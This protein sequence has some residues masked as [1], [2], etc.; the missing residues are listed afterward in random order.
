MILEHKN[1]DYKNII[2][3][4]NS[5]KITDDTKIKGFADLFKEATT[6]N[7]FYGYFEDVNDV[8]DLP[9]ETRVTNVETWQTFYYEIRQ[10]RALLNNLTTAKNSFYKFLKY[11]NADTNESYWFYSLPRGFSKGADTI[12]ME[13][14]LNKLVRVP[15]LK[16]D[17]SARYSFEFIAKISDTVGVCNIT[18]RT[19]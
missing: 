11:T 12:Q 4:Y 18:N 9:T 1:M 15:I 14:D 13:I 2:P 7:K 8:E 6:S 16:N 19:N 10:E 17:F 3:G 5:K